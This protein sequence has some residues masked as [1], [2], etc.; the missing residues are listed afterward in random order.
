MNKAPGGGWQME[1]TVQRLAS[2]QEMSVEA[3]MIQQAGPLRKW[4][5]KVKQEHLDPKE[6][7]KGATILWN[8]FRW[9]II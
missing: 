7:D 4:T 1:V 2:G 5:W 3:Q 6:Q 9:E 8:V